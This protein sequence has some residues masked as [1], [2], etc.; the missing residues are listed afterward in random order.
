MKWKRYDLISV[1]SGI[2]T[3]PLCLIAFEEILGPST[4]R[5]VPN[6]YFYLWPLVFWLTGRILYRLVR[7]RSLIFGAL[8]Y[9]YFIWCLAF[10]AFD[11]AGHRVWA[12]PDDLV[13]R[14]IVFGSIG[15][16]LGIPLSLLVVTLLSRLG[17]DQS[18]DVHPS[19]GTQEPVYNA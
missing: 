8:A 5:P 14:G 2:L 1:S 6:Y 11:V 19:T 16:P 17:V 3:L 12:S 13:L 9:N 15:A 7:K 4:P 10:F 18:Q